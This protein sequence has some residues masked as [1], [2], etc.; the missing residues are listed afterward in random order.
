VNLTKA[1][2]GNYDSRAERVD[3]TTHAA[4]KFR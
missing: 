1:C 4:V 3:L 2:S